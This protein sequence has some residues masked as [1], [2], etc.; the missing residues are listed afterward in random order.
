[1]EL[2]TVDFET[3]WS[4]EHSLTK[5]SPLEY[6]RH[7]ET[8]LISLAYKHGGE[9][10]EV[11]F[12]EAAMRA[13]AKTV[14]WHETYVVAHNM[15]GFDSMLLA[16]RLGVRPA[17]WGC[18]LAMARPRYSKTQA[19]MP[20]GSLRD[21]VSLAKLATE[22]GLPA[23]GSLEATNTK[24]KHLGDF[25]TTE[26]AAMAEYNKL[27]VDLCYGL[28]RVLAV[29]TGKREMQLVDQ[30]IRM[31]VEPAF[32]LD[33]PALQDALIQEQARKRGLLLDVATMVGGYKPGMDDE[34][35]AE[36]ARQTLASAPKF[37]HLLKELGVEVPMKGSPTTGR[38]IPALAKT[39]EEFVA[40]QEHPDEIVATAAQARLGVKSSL[41]ET[42]IEAFLQAGEKDG[43]LPVPLKYAGA[44]TTWRWSGWAYNPQNLPRIGKTPKPSDVLRNSI[45]APEGMVIVAVD[46]SGIELRVNHFLWQV[47]ES[48]KAFQ[49]DPGEADLYRDFAAEFYTKPREEVTADE[50][51]FAKVTQLGLGFGA[52][53]STFMKI[54]RLMG[55]IAVDAKQAEETVVFW[56]GMYHRIVRGWKWGQ[57]ALPSVLAGVRTT[58]DP[59]GLC[60][61]ASGGIELPR[62]FIAY[63]GLRKE[64]DEWV[65]GWGRNKARIYGPKVVENVVQSIARHVLADNVLAIHEETG[66]R[67]AL[68][69]HDEWVG[70]VK[71][72]EAEAVLAAVLRIT[73]TPPTW[74]PEL[75]VWSKGGVGKTYGETK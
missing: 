57:K 56:R 8:E 37:A 43:Q 4:V 14:P 53:P 23:K 40:L 36:S 6:V 52:G 48:M 1:M 66:Y 61:T 50:R 2:L 47:E 73:R 33:I 45:R 65:Y 63:P 13:W 62:G 39:D 38:Q 46:L 41:L 34:A 30:T 74:W 51:Q 58:L 44:D 17:M 75:V 42:R 5:M 35:A 11:V 28:F 71:D 55:G 64:E 16:W 18:T 67:A 70:V 60:H 72:A 9:P 29:Q 31:L 15:E 68:L 54:A 12:G 32:V 26:L 25:T 20:D 49:A 22:F 3:F 69:V 7:P 59:W 21:G 10:T 27:D 24:G 19:A